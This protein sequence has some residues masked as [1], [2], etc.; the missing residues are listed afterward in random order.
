[1]FAVLLTIYLSREDVRRR[2]LAVVNVKLDSSVSVL[3]CQPLRARCGLQRCKTKCNT[4]SICWPEVVK[5]VPYWGLVFM[6]AGAGFLCLFVM[7]WACVVFCFLVF[8]SHYQCN[9]LP[10]MTHLQSNLTCYVSSE[11]LNPTH[12]LVFGVCDDGLK[13]SGHG[14]RCFVAN[15]QMLL[16]ANSLRRS[17]VSSN[18]KDDSV[19]VACIRITC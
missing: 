19:L 16:Y 3:L 17:E 8:G 7:F 18:A 12:S 14:F 2:C 1:M 4:C 9:Q 15:C 13:V 10:G 6:L 5:V 11:W